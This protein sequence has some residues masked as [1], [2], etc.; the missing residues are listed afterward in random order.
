MQWGKS[1]IFFQSKV[2]LHKMHSLSNN[3]SR[4]FKFRVD[5]LVL[6]VFLPWEVEGGILIKKSGGGGFISFSPE[7]L[8][9][10]Y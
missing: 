5:L 10:E 8:I 1:I 9:S 3:H 6:A 2:S 4:A 7:G